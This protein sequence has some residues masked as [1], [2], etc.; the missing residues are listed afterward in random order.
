MTMVQPAPSQPRDG[1]SVAFR[2][3]LTLLGVATF[4]QGYAAALPVR[5][6]GDAA[7]SFGLSGDDVGP[8]L[9]LIAV[10]S[11]AALLV[12][13]LS[14]RFGRRGVLIWSTIL[15]AVFSALT[16]TA[17]NLF[18]FGLWSLAARVFIVAQ[19]AAVIT[20]LAE[21]SPA[22][23]RGWAIGVVTAAGGL[24]GI[25]LVLVDRS[26]GG[27][28]GWRLVALTSAV[29]ALVALWMRA[30]LPESEK[31]IRVEERVRLSQR[32]I[33][34]FRRNPGQLFQVGFLFLLVDAA[35][36]GG[37]AWWGRYALDEL[38]FT[39]ASVVAVVSVSYGFG[40]FGYLFGGW[41]S[42][43]VGRRTS[44]TYLLFA[45]GILG[46]LA[47]ENSSSV[48]QAPLTVLATFCGLA[49]S[50]MISAMSAELFALETRTT[51]V[52]FVRGV[53]GTAGGLIGPLLVGF[54]ADES[55]DIVGN[56]GDSVSLVALAL[57]PAILLLRFLPESAGRDLA[58]LSAAARIPPPDASF[59][60]QLQGQE[61]PDHRPPGGPE[62]QHGHG[63]PPE[64]IQRPPHQT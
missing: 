33:P 20:M 40:I 18:L 7:R 31:W 28:G 49:V 19:Y 15:I 38:K 10:G 42:D 14:D 1:T 13:P 59:V 52:A 26:I 12:A 9:F 30:R 34:L 55:V 35:F 32:R 56:I 62:G 63:P 48:L 8:A 46:I 21:E 36:F 37:A 23:Q 43:R 50:P 53:F 58:S 45:A 27:P 5:V 29:G 2:T 6:A 3:L 54:L 57:I 17:L 64:P 25:L 47:F 41:I 22:K 11:V 16:A 39:E 44:G 61:H 24:G 4:F 51:S 60:M